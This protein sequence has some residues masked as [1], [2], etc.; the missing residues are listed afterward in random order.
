MCGA[1][2]FTGAVQCQRSN[3]QLLWKLLPVENLPEHRCWRPTAAGSHGVLMAPP[4]P[5]A[6]NLNCC[7]WWDPGH[8]AEVQAPPTPRPGRR[9]LAL[10]AV[11]A[12]PAQL[13][14]LLCPPSLLAA[15]ECVLCDLWGLTNICDRSTLVPGCIWPPQSHSTGGPV[16]GAFPRAHWPCTPQP[17][18]A[19]VRVS[20]L[21]SN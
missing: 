4:T 19:C 12:P 2:T 10:G 17:Y 7:C 13:A 16:H 18:P 6:L 15:P 5:G 3:S 9:T 21:A 14:L 8:W 20:P 11:P 1:V